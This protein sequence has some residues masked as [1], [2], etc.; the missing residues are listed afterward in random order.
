MK[1]FPKTDMPLSLHRQR[2]AG[3]KTEWLKWTV[4]PFQPPCGACIHMGKN[5]LHIAQIH[6]G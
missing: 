3:I 6:M 5:T 2:Y 1:M 4:Q